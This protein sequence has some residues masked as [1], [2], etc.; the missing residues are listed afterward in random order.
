MQQQAP[1]PPACHVTYGD[2]LF[3]YTPSHLTAAQE[4]AALRIENTG[5]HAANQE[6]A[7]QLHRFHLG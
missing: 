1:L 4:A 7:E 5:L 2:S 3:F 6:L